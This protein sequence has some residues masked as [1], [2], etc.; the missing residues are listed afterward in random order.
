MLSFAV[1][2]LLG[3]VFLHLLPEVWSHID[4]DNHGSHTKIGL[5]VISGLL[6]F[7]IV[8]K[9]LGDEQEFEHLKDTCEEEEDLAEQKL[10][11]IQPCLAP[12]TEKTRKRNKVKV[13]DTKSTTKLKGQNGHKPLPV[14][15]NNNCSTVSGGKENKEHIKISGYLNLLANVV[16]N[17]THGLAV[18]GSF[19]ISTK[20]GLVT[21][22]A[23][24]LHEIPHEVGDFAILLRS[25]F[26]RWKA[27]K[28]QF[29]T[30]SG[31]VIG[32]I[33]ALSAE[34]AEIAGERTA[35]ILPFTSGGFMYIALVTVVP[36][37]LQEKHGWESFKQVAFICL[38]ILTMVMVTLTFD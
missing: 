26:D 14:A 33:T 30:A 10:K 18:A 17:F 38:G 25:G 9:L 35:W 29:L 20:V 1:G 11:Q 4:R 16:D 27:A 13:Q 34:S 24:L 6:A 32:A 7:M 22:L 2:S 23:I 21:T 36:D 3:D 8:E 28:A 12:Q 31:S 37:L 5:W 19:C 15:S